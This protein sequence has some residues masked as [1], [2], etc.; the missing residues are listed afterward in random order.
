MNRIIPAI[1]TALLRG[2][3]ISLPATTARICR[4]RPANLRH[5]DQV[6]EVVQHRLRPSY[7][8]IQDDLLGA[9]QGKALHAEMSREAIMVQFLEEAVNS[10]MVTID[11]IGEVQIVAMSP[12][13]RRIDEGSFQFKVIAYLPV[14]WAYL[15]DY[16]PDSPKGSREE[17]RFVFLLTAVYIYDGQTGIVNIEVIPGPVLGT[18]PHSEKG[19]ALYA[20][21]LEELRQQL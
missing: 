8:Q 21:H 14:S 11:A 18:Y 12:R 10:G 20:E 4:W 9:I 16:S 15:K 7:R 6:P 3:L 19:E 5:R 1:A 2:V 17:S 13:P